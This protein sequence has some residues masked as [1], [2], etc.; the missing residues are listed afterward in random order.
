[1]SDRFSEDDVIATVTRLTRPQ[2]V[3]FIEA[4]FVKPDRDEGG[5]QF[6]RIDIARLEL[7]CDLTSDLDLNET[8][9]AVVISLL[10]QLHAA[11]HERMAMAQTLNALPDD[12]RSVILAAMAA[13]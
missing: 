3:S 7:L 2:L 9:L 1:M 4:E 13:P 10:D 8:A 6:R 5:Y 12:L 11:R